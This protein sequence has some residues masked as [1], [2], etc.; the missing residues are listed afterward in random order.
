MEPRARPRFLGSLTLP[1]TVYKAIT[2]RQRD[3][4]HS[5]SD[6]FMI[7]QAIS[8]ACLLFA[9]KSGAPHLLDEN[10]REVLP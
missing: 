4:S 8:G 10:A 3:I 9:W 2:Y 7:F 1:G 5:N 6:I